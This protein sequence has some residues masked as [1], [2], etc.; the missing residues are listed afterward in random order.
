MRVYHEI[1][2]G[3]DVHKKSVTACVMWGP[4]GREPEFEIRRFGTTTAEL[5]ELATWLQPADCTIV[6]MES[7]G[8]Y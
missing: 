6:A 5:E 8:S 1:C 7:T 2:C 4:A 3:L